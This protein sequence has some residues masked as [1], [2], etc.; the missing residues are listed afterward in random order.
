MCLHTSIYTG[1]LS[2]SSCHSSIF[3]IFNA[4]GSSSHKRFKSLRCFSSAI[5]KFVLFALFLKA[6]SDETCHY[7]LSSSPLES[8]PAH[9]RGRTVV[10]NYLARLLV[11]LFRCQVLRHERCI[12]QP[13]FK[14]LFYKAMGQLVPLIPIFFSPLTISI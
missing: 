7:P 10:L 13:Y 5:C 14:C 8:F 3:P 12:F 6:V 2:L 11:R 4:R 1:S 9:P